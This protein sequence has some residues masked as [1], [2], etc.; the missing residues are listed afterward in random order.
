MLLSRRD[1]LSHDIIRIAEAK[2]A[3]RMGKIPEFAKARSVAC[4]YSMGSEVPTHT[5][6]QGL[7][8]SGRKVCLPSI[9]GEDLVFREVRDLG[10][11]ESGKFD[12][13]EPRNDCEECID[14]DVIIVPAVGTAR[15][16]S[17]LGYGR[18]Y[19][20]RFLAGLDIPS[21]V[22]C[23]SKQLV[24]SVPTEE[25][26]IPVNWIVTEDETIRV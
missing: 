26:D 24:K 7:L 2:I 1:S 9:P 6:M 15:D 25:H 17:R 10:R 5:L 23:Y 8:D 16:G 19:Y 13:M 11:L 3:R 12:I 14:P 22:P 18:G 21:I 20:D 4:Y